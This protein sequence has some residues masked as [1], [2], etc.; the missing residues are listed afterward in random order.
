MIT[1]L[2]TA[3]AY[4]WILHFNL[5]S[6]MRLRALPPQF[7]VWIS[8]AIISWC[9]ANKPPVDE[10]GQAP[11]LMVVAAVNDKQVSED[12]KIPEELDSSRI[13]KRIGYVS[14]RDTNEVSEREAVQARR[15]NRVGPNNPTDLVS[16]KKP[17][18]KCSQRIWTKC[19]FR[20]N[21][22]Y[23]PFKKRRYSEYSDGLMTLQ[24]CSILT[25]WASICCTH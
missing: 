5:V 1:R 17:H 3:E 8:L 10:Q 6:T 14:E 13:S 24:I 20:E 23:L 4:V 11:K 25:R 16:G 18:W 7:H 9:V 21:Y 2:Q 12:K 15:T 22:N 19:R